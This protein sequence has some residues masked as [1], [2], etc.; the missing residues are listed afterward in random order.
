MQG[1]VAG[2]L[3]ARA[4]ALLTD[5]RRMIVDIGAAWLG[6]GLGLG[7]GVGVGVRLRPRH[8]GSGSGL[9]GVRG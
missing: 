7:L 3:D 8:T 6:L 2:D 5:A 1:D 9:T 4:E